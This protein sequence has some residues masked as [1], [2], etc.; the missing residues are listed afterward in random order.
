M[1][2]MPY[3]FPGVFS[4]ENMTSPDLTGN[5]TITPRLNYKILI[6]LVVPASSCEGDKVIKRF[7]IVVV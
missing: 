7:W 2:L 6:A 4:H 1:L 3:S 5:A